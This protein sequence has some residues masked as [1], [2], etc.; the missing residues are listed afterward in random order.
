VHLVSEPVLENFPGA[1]V[2]VFFLVR[3]NS[4]IR[5]QIPT[6]ISLA[7]FGSSAGMTLYRFAVSAQSLSKTRQ[8]F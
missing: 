1:A 7:F 3:L 4:L 8:V 2:F 5:I 6:T